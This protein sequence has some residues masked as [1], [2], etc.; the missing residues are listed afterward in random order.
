M[1]KLY[2]F[3][4]KAFRWIVYF[5]FFLRVEGKEHIPKEGNFIIVSNH[6]SALDPVIIVVSGPFYLRP[7][8]KKELYKFK[9]F[10][11][12]LKKL[13]CIKVDRTDG[14][15]ALAMS[16]RALGRGEIMLIF[17]E[18]TRS[19]TREL[20]EFKS[21][22]VALAIK[23]NTPLIPCQVIEPK[24]PRLFSGI[25]VRF[26]PMLSPSD[27]DFGKEDKHY[28]KGTKVIRD[29]C[30]ALRKGEMP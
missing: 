21:G 23:T 18:G 11:F 9:P 14:A 29:A 7:M 12:I 2:R 1:T 15:Q 3:A 5:L 17:A 13:G 30:M 6:V 10:G 25:K 8:A 4:V 19:K 20:L 22:A 28:L 24:G 16:K 26:G 27:V